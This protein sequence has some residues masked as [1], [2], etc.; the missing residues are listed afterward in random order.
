VDGVQEQFL[1]HHGEPEAELRGQSPPFDHA[2]YGVEQAREGGFIGPQG[3]LFEVHVHALQ[4]SSG[5]AIIGGRHAGARKRD[6]HGKRWLIGLAASM[7][8]APLAAP[9]ADA[10]VVKT[11][12]GNVSIERGGTVLTAELGLP[13]Q[14]TD[15]IVTGPDGAVGITFEDNALLSLGPDSRLSIGQ[16]RFDSTTHDGAFETTLTRGRLAVVSGK[17]AKHKQDA[18]KVRTP[19]SILGVRGTE[20]LV[21]VSSAP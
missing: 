15:V 20:F 5:A 16:F 10:G 6:M 7:L 14:V 2:R 19:S 21:E 13:V 3:E 4:P 12:Q 11:V 9:A 17:I 8:I 18:M 1:E